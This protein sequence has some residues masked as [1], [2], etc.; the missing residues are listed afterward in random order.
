MKYWG[1]VF[2]TLGLL[3]GFITYRNKNKISIY[4]RYRDIEII[5]ADKYFKLQ[6]KY[7]LVGSTVVLVCGLIFYIGYDY[8]EYELIL[9]PI[10]SVIFF[11]LCNYMLFR[12]SLA[13]KWIK[14]E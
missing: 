4:I 10:L 6:M 14:K 7:G 2:A 11:N 9:V 3:L 12:V 13:K 1:L 5:E 8:F